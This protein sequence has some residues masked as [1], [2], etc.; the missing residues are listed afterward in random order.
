MQFALDAKTAKCDGII[1]SPLELEFLG[2]EEELRSLLKVTPGIRPEWM[3]AYDQ[4]RTMTPAQAIKAGATMLVIG[5]PITQ[6]PTEIGT[7]TDAVKKI[8]EEIASA[9]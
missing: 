9:L 7:P 4:R 5:R 3:P 1:S 2:K 8:M 6:P